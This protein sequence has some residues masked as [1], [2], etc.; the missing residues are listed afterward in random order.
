MPLSYM[1]PVFP[2]LIVQTSKY[3]IVKASRDSHLLNWTCFSSSASVNWSLHNT[4]ICLIF[5]C[6]R[7]VNSSA[8][9][10]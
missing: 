1:I 10:Y 7:H 3:T 8:Q 9:L 4:N 5:T 2:S 6:L